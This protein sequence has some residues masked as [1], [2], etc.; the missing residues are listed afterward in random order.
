MSPDFPQPLAIF[1]PL[2]REKQRQQRKKKSTERREQQFSTACYFRAKKKDNIQYT[3]TPNPTQPVFPTSHIF[4]PDFYVN[5]FFLKSFGV[6]P[7]FVTSC[8]HLLQ[9]STWWPNPS[10][11]RSAANVPMWPRQAG[12]GE[13]LLQSPSISLSHAILTPKFTLSSKFL[14]F[15]Y[16]QN[17]LLMYIFI[18]F[19]LFCV[20]INSCRYVV[21]NSL[22]RIFFCVCLFMYNVYVSN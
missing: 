3:P 1:K 22:I 10:H 15:H 16:C 7:F 4:F 19:H 5:F 12:T 17:S 18:G 11:T 14:F 2:E 8:W 13:C 6:V 20:G 9:M 21:L